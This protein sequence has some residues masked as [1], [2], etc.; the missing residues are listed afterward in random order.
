MVSTVSLEK[1]VVELTEEPN[2]GPHGL[3]MLFL[4]FYICLGV[5]GKNHINKSPL[6][7]KH[8]L[9]PEKRNK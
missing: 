3:L 5:L 8:V 2:R 9:A 1:L 4:R 6:G 7:A